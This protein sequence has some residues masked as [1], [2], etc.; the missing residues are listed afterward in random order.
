MHYQSIFRPGLFEGKVIIVTG[1]GS[2]IGRCVAHELGWLGA[3][4]V[5]VGRNSEKLERVKTEITAE[6]GFVSAQVCDIRNDA[7]V[8]A[9]V[10]AVLADHGRIDGL[11][12]N[13]GGQFFSPLKDIST[14]G[15]EA[16][17]RNNLV[18]GFI[19]MREVY[20]RWM[21][22]HGGAIVNM[23]ADM[24]N[25]LPGCAHSG[26]ARAGMNSLTESAACEWAASGVRV[27]SVAPG[28]IASSGFDNYTGEAVSKILGYTATIPAQ[29]YGTVAEVSAAIVFLLSPAS[30][31]I[32]G[33]CIRVDG[34]GPNA[35]SSWKLQ[36][37][38]KSVPFDGFHL[39]STPDLLKNDH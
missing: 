22:Q 36:P 7:A 8:L 26:S 9:V 23:S 5:I 19:F 1:G 24:W 18:G 25:G 12:N 16:V 21:E 30:A 33:T 38:N 14:K 11:V 10:D 4:V 31:F 34:G 3:C 13:A 35:R 17:V 37:H 6:G 32:T 29:R 39:D 2:G 20:A 15:F 27:N 28:L